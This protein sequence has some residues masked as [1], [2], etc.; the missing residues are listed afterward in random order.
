MFNAESGKYMVSCFPDELVSYGIDYG[1][2]CKTLIFGNR[3][4]L[5]LLQLYQWNDLN[6]SACF[7][8]P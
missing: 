1:P 5:A 8:V 2:Y 7:Y 3:I 6:R 4:N